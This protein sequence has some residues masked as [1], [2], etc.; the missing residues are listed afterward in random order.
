MKLNNYQGLEFEVILEKGAETLLDECMWMCTA[1]SD[2]ISVLNM[3]PS[4]VTALNSFYFYKRG[5]ISLCCFIENLIHTMAPNVCCFCFENSSQLPLSI[6]AHS[7]LT[8]PPLEEP[9]EMTS[10]EMFFF[11]SLNKVRDG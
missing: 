7:N 4:H 5:F 9:L 6:V 8:S 2:Y 1:D 3:R 10:C 11:S